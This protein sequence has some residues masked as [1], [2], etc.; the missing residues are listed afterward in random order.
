MSLTSLFE[1]WI[2][3][4]PPECV[5]EISERALA[6]GTPRN[7]GPPTVLTLAEPSLAASPSAPNLLK[8]DAYRNAL[9]GMAS[10]PGQRKT[11]AL[12]IPDYAVRMSLLD[13]QDFPDAE[14]ERLALL[15][16]RLR[17]SVP[18]HIE[19]SQLSYSV[20]S[21]DDK[22]IEVLAVAIARPILEEYENLF[23]SS[24]FRV[25]LVTPSSI[26]ALPLFANNAGGLTLVLKAAGRTVSVLLT[27]GIRI[28]LVRALD[29]SLG[30]GEEGQVG[31]SRADALLGVVQ[32]T[33]A[34]AEDQIGS[35]VSRILLCGLDPT[36]DFV[37]LLARSDFS[38][39]VT[40][41]RSRFGIASPETAG[42]LGLMEQYAA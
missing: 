16:F 7:P 3:E 15:R 2:Q 30:E 38:I 36:D 6:Q 11:A 21:Q 32:Q 18:F 29:L 42:V 37:A 41:V 33:A 31:E 8:S 14:N 28:R 40:A 12:V 22:H 9:A 26:A 23:V 17:K 39:P 1:K 27:Q 24:G 4:P 5:F 35:P 34:F 20:Q 13:F 10:A 25:G 19:E